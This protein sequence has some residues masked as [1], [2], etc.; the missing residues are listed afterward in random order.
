VSNHSTDSGKKGK[1]T[2][3]IKKNT[4]ITKRVSPDTDPDCIYSYRMIPISAAMVENMIDELADWPLKH[5]EAT[6]ITEYYLSKGLRERTYFRLLE[7]YPLLKE[8]HEI[9]MRRLGERMW[10]QAVYNKANWNPIKHRLWSYAKEFREDAD[11][12]SEIASKSREGLL[13]GP[14]T[15]INVI[16]M[17]M[18]KKE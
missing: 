15:T 7:R 2:N 4:N 6:T 13:G 16:D 12:N 17:A 18:V 11:F 8:S 10:T 3:R 14:N 5:P 9:A 1:I